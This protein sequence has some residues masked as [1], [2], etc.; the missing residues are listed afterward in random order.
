MHKPCTTVEI[1]I[2]LYKPNFFNSFVV[3]NPEN[4]SPNGPKEATNPIVNSEYPAYF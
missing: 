4:I 2:I 3:K 1:K